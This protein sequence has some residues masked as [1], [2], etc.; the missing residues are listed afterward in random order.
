MRA[1]DLTTAARWESAFDAGNFGPVETASALSV[2]EGVCRGRRVRVAMTDRSIRGG[3]FGVEECDALSRTL[4]RS[5]DDAMPVALVLD[6]GG[7][8]L[9][10]GLA[11]LGAFRRMYRIALDVRLK[12]VPT[13]AL[14][15]RNCFGGASMLAMLCATRAALR[16]GRV[17]MSGP[18]I[19]EALSGKP[20]LDSSDRSAVDELFGAPARAESGAIDLLFDENDSFGDVLYQLIGNDAQMPPDIREQ[21][22]RLRQRLEGAGARLQEAQSVDACDAFQS[23][24]AVG[25]RDI[26]L[27]ADKIISAPA[28]QPMT[29][30]VDC[31][32]QAATRRDERVVLSEY[33]VHLA[34]CLRSYRAE[35]GTMVM[36]VSGESAGG[37][38]V[39]LA[40]GVDT[41]HASSQAVLRVLPVAAVN[42]VLRRSLPDE[43]L[44]HALDAGVVDRIIHA[45][46]NAASEHDQTASSGISNG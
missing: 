43:T 12:G 19:V 46:E 44:Q 42:T 29:L 31:P 20:D 8:R 16:T 11:G 37:I 26:W 5:L 27:L 24:R 1:S 45:R 33:V 28:G 39:A 10:A 9:D 38:Y 32:G 34:L 15:L 13:C 25:A 35:G 30:T 18:A 3:S 17:G 22:K 23:G 2:A 36:H 40:A 4:E 7:A 14:M 21:H 6:S 41:V